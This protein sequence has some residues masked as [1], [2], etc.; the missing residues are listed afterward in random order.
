M[1]E[2][3]KFI[4]T[5][6]KTFD[7]IKKAINDLVNRAVDNVVDTVV[8]DVTEF[9]PKDVRKK[10]RQSV[11]N[12]RKTAAS[13]GYTSEK[14]PTERP[15]TSVTENNPEL[16][17]RK[18]APQSSQIYYPPEAHSENISPQEEYM[19]TKIGQMRELEICVRGQGIVKRAVEL[20]LAE[21]GD[22]MAD[23]EDDFARQAF[24]ALPQPVYAAMSNSQLRTYFTWR[25]DVRRGKYPK[26]DK[27]YVLLYC[28]EL[29]NKVGVKNSVEAFEK[30]LEVWGKCKDFAPYLN[31][32]MPRWLRDFYAFN[33]I[34]EKYPDI[35]AVLGEQA[36]IRFEREFTEIDAGNYTGKFEFLAENSAY[37]VKGSIFYSDKT[38]PLLEAACER[39]LYALDDYFKA[40]DIDISELL[41]GKLKKDYSWTPF[42]D[43]IVNLDRT[44]GF[45][46]VKISA[47]V[48]YCVKRGEPALEMFDFA[49]SK[50]FIGYLLKSVE[51]ELR[52]KTGFNRRIVPKLQ[53][54]QNDFKNRTKLMNAVSEPDFLK[55]IPKA[56]DEY[57]AEN[58]IVPPP[59]AKKSQEETVQ[60]S[61]QKVEIDVS[62]LAEIRDKSD[63]LA[64]KL[65]V[66]E[67]TD[68]PII[69][70]DFDTAEQIVEQIS[71]DDFSARIDEVKEEFSP[72]EEE[73]PVQSGNPMFE[74]LDPDWQTF[75]N[76]LIPIQ[77][78]TLKA[79]LDGNVKEFCKEKN[80][81]PETVFEEINTEALSA[82]GDVVIECGEL[83]P[84]YSGE[85]EKI[86]KA[87]L[88]RK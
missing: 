14:I 21:Q 29:L 68:E 20:T 82:F 33:D 47:S 15:K 77:I 56:V 37:D 8:N 49:P 52:I 19:L 64:K 24:C 54:L 63:E 30:L 27:P 28:Y 16:T 32:L 71:D 75:A 81:L 85:V 84:D 59:K 34:T 46:A 23:V 73:I 4:Q 72:Q 48:R 69:T 78:E 57:C 39:A 3:K 25:T 50:G 43:A 74:D 55:I 7:E 9:A 62:K 61:A 65:I 86:V 10:V 80:L 2:F 79:L 58:G 38:K 83:V 31:T 45:R 5:S 60:Y 26:T 66:D 22:F 44:D 87:V 1:G 70:E 42:R 11:D 88:N 51:A 67:E 6:G 12:I 13:G 53:M 76:N 18:N 41:C 35:N 36:E 40:R 17:R